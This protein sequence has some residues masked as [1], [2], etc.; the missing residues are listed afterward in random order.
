MV[1][2]KKDKLEA[3]KALFKKKKVLTIESLFKLLK[4]TSRMTVHRYLKELDYL[5]SYSHKGQY[6]TLKEITQFDANGLWHYDEIGFSKHGTLF[7][8]V[9]YFVNS[10]AEGMT[11][12][13][14]EA[15]SRTVVKYALLDLVEKNK[16]SR[17]KPAH[18]YVYLNSDQI[19]AEEQLKRRRDMIIDSVDDAVALRV[20]L[21]AYR[22]VEA[23]L[24][25]EQIANALKKEGSDISLQVVRQIFQYY[26]LGKKTLDF[27]SSQ[28]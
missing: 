3:I 28:S 17:A 12:S 22:M 15:E 21:V 4:T 1:T 5:T 24:S 20:L 11:S 26:G 23:A 8:T 2:A 9:T 18:V 10:S 6:Y 25:P 14:L 19:K 7:N 27:T 16:L 13:E